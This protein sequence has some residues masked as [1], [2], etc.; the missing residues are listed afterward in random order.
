VLQ[1][2]IGPAALAM[3]VLE[4]RAQVRQDSSDDDAQLALGIRAVTT[5]AQTECRR[6]LIASRLKLVLDAFPGRWGADSISGEATAFIEYGPILALK[7]ITYLDM[8]GT[9]QTLATTEYT[10]DSS[11]L[12]TR[13]APLFGKVWP[14]TLP[15]LGAVEITFDAGDAAAITATANVLTIKGGIWKPLAVGD[16]VR[17]SNSGGALPAPLQQDTDYYVQSTP[18]ATSFTV[19][20]TFGGSA[21]A[22]T[23][24]GSGTNYIGVVDEGLK[25]WMKL[26][27][28]SLYDLRADLN[29][30][31]RGKLE[32]LPYIDQLL[33]PHR[34]PL[35]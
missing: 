5:F 24:A 19:S 21:I 27:A 22:L 16:T 12:L 17:L 10:V 8:S 14:P 29:V 9:R 25:A 30:L 18:T 4:M 11:G 20:A 34:S 26:R 15:Q 6:T 31:N 33:D 35:A 2:L 13:I 7:S 32:P 3:D 1:T 23:D 28:S